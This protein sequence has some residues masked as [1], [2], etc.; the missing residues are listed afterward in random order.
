MNGCFWA[1]INP[2]EFPERKMDLSA[3][4]PQ[5]L[6]DT[7]RHS[8]TLSHVFHEWTGLLACREL[9]LRTSW[10]RRRRRVVGLRGR[11]LPGAAEVRVGRGLSCGAQLMGLVGDSWISCGGSSHTH[12]HLEGQQESKS[13]K[14]LFTAV[15]KTVGI[16]SVDLPR[17]GR[18]GPRP[19]AW[20]P[21]CGRRSRRSRRA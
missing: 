8:E 12:H 4:V 15:W 17:L 3:T 9:Q 19:R 18:P 14:Y 1:L 20:R 13:E 6:Q 7:V 21:R 5:E 10:T 2:S 11:S 16:R